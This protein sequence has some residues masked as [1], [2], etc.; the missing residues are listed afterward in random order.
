VRRAPLTEAL[1]HGCR[2]AR[3][4]LLAVFTRRQRSLIA[5]VRVMLLSLGGIGSSRGWTPV[6]IDRGGRGKPAMTRC[7]RLSSC[8]V[9]SGL[10]STS[11]AVS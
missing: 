6:K 5:L 11:D 2:G 3:H 1:P 4:G 9:A 7:S 10:D 8:E